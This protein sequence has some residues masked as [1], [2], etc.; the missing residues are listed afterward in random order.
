ML[1]DDVLVV[2]QLWDTAGQERF[3]SVTKQY[4]RKADGVVIMYD[5]TSE[6]TLISMRHWMAS[7]QDSVGAGTVITLIGNKTDL[8]QDDRP[9]S[10]KD[11]ARL[12]DEYGYL[13]YETSVKTGDN[14]IESITGLALLLKDKEDK[15]IERT[16]LDLTTVTPESSLP[17]CNKS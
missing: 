14:V 2:L 11:G 9:V 15:Q 10:Y 4:F 13:F 8:A 3:R 16:M 12:A 6:K 17:C 7:I 1:V 5:V